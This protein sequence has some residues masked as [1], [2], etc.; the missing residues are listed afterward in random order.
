MRHELVRVA[1][2][3]DGGG[4]VVRLGVVPGLADGIGLAGV[5]LGY[6]QQMLGVGAR[7]QVVSFPTPAAEGGALAAGRL[8][9]AYLDPVTAV[10]LWLAVPGSQ[11][12][13]VA[14]AATGTAEP[15]PRGR[16]AS[17][18]LVFTQK[19]LAGQPT[20]ATAV[21]KGDILAS[22]ILATDPARG[23]SAIAAELAA[24]LGRRVPVKKL[25]VSFRQVSY[26]NDPLASSV[27]AEARHA[28]AAGLLRPLPQSLAGLYYLGP[29][30]LLSG[31]QDRVDMVLDT[32]KAPRP[33]GH[34][35]L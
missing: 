34:N 20:L 30:V 13:V 2:A 15:G 11:V 21:L 9:A 23:R 6:F 35:S 14:G 29:L 25:A 5:Q 4:Q 1:K 10:R 19:F 16:S 26:T 32:R 18:L 3:S 28:V 8:D 7:L 33:P 22:Q 27:L 24:L 17:T 31:E 12:K